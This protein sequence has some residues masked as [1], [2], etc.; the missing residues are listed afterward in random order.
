[1]NGKGSKPRPYSNY[2]NYLDNYENINWDKEYICCSE[3]GQPYKRVDKKEK[4]RQDSSGDWVCMK[5]NFN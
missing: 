5:C 1:M 3:C 4:M 2:T